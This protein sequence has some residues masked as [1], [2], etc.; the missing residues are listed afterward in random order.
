MKFVEGQYCI[1]PGTP[2][3][4]GN[5]IYASVGSN[6]FTSDLL[7]IRGSGHQDTRQSMGQCSVPAVHGRYYLTIDGGLQSGRNDVRNSAKVAILAQG[8]N[9]KIG[10]L[11][12]GRF[13]LADRRPPAAPFISA[14]RCIQFIPDAKLVLVIGRDLQ[15]IGFTAFDAIATLDK[16]GLSR[17]NVTSQPIKE[18]KRGA[19]CVSIAGGF[20]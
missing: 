13:S 7:F 20:K 3:A 12:E 9:T 2:N 8:S 10:T 6:Q 11:P 14:E 4:D 5:I 17:L 19:Q 1:T 15:R 18:A 16:A